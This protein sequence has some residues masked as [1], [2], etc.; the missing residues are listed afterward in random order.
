[1][2]AIDYTNG[3]ITFTEA[4]DFVVGDRV[5][6]MYDW[7]KSCLPY[8]IPTG[9]KMGT[10]PFTAEIAAIT[11][12]TITIG[13]IDNANAENVD[14]S[15][16]YLFKSTLVAIDVSKYVG[17]SIRVETIGGYFSTAGSALVEAG[18][19]ILSSYGDWQY[20]NGYFHT[21]EEWSEHPFVR[22]SGVQGSRQ[23][24]K[25]RDISYEFPSSNGA[26]LTIKTLGICGTPGTI[27]K[28]T[29]LD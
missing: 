22:I 12:T 25:W 9:L 26:K 21:L 11:D 23:S 10:W 7:S 18:T 13:A 20:P 3:V 15:K 6:A 24:D 19:Q 14:F 5:Y 4:H 16:F 28:I 8:N 2:S 17:H 27:I 29:I 1:V